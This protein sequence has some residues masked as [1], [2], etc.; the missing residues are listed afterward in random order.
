MKRLWAPWRIEYILNEKPPGCIFCV[1][2]EAE[3]DREKLILHRTPLSFVMLNRY[4]YTNGHL[5]VAPF[6]HT[7]DMN[8]LS[9]GEMLDL[10]STLRLCR[11]VLQETSQ[12]QGFNVGINLGKAA[13]AGVDEHIHIHIVPRWNGDTNYMSVIADLRVMPENLMATYDGLLPGF[14]AGN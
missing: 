7:S 1:T 4:P 2:D 3:K 8:S 14:M 10:F 12:P 5:M 9:D 13:G 6:R 11:N